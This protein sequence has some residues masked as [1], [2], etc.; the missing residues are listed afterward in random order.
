MKRIIQ[1]VILCFLL[2][3][4]TTISQERVKAK[5]GEP[6]AVERALNEKARVMDFKNG[7]YWMDINRINAM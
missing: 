6:T 3:I 4:Q 5:F 2:I 7:S 1:K